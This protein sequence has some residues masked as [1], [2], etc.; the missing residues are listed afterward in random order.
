MEEPFKKIVEESSVNCLHAL[1][2][3]IFVC[4]VQV[5]SDGLV[6][7]IARAYSIQVY[8]CGISSAHLEL[9][10]RKKCEWQLKQSSTMNG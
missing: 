10:E 6:C 3:Y 1:S 7:F 8:I 9:S 4:L 5:L 2:N